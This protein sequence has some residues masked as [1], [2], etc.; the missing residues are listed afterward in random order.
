MPRFTAVIRIRLP[1]VGLLCLTAFSAEAHILFSA[2]GTGLDYGKAV[3]VDDAGNVYLASYF[4]NTVDFAPGPGVS[5]LVA[6][7]F[8]DIAITKHDA[9]GNLLW[10]RQVTNTLPAP[11]QSDIPHGIVLDAATNILFTGYFSGTADFDSGTGATLR[12]SSGGYDTFVAK[13]DAA[14]AFQWVQTFGNTNAGNTTEERNY[15]LAVEPSGFAYA[16]GYFEGAITPVATQ[17]QTS[18]GGQDGIVVKYAP[19]GTPLWSMRIGGATNDQAQALA[20]DGLGHLFVLGSFRGANIDFDPGAGISNLSSV[21]A[22]TD[23]FLARYTTNA[24]LDWVVRIGG[25]GFEQGAPGGMSADREGNVYLTGRFQ[26]T[27][28]FDP[29]PAVSNLTSVGGDDLFVASYTA[30]GALRWAFGV[31]GNGLDGGHRARLDP[32]TNVIVSGWFTGNA[33]FDGGAGTAVVSAGSTNGGS[34]AFVAK[35]G[36]DGA[37]RWVRS[38]RPVVA[39]TNDGISAG[40]WVDGEGRSCATGQ[41]FGNTLF[42]TGYGTVTLT[43]AGSSDLFLVRLAPDGALAGPDLSAPAMTSSG[44]TFRVQASAGRTYWVDTSTNAV[45]WSVVATNAVVP[46]PFDVTVPASSPSLLFRTR[47]W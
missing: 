32:Q 46:G 4:Q 13:L 21:G 8:V 44:V 15:D 17:S 30:S 28:D 22:G 34:D 33:D 5:N 6:S 9:G 24:A 37:F 14:G 3:T 11:A 41:F 45:T 1:R 47:A 7:S 18:A 42:E 16:A 43:N 29:G 20:I 31:G 2:G 35:Y 23:L 25:N 26:Q 38:L 27:V 39:N 40:L 19:D 12:T 10:V 36:P